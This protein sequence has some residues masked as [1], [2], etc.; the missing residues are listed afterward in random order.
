MLSAPERS[1]AALNFNAIITL[2]QQVG[3]Q[4]LEAMQSLTE[5]HQRLG[6]DLLA[7]LADNQAQWLGSR[8]GA[9]AG[10][11]LIRQF[12]PAQEP[13]RHYQRQLLDLVSMTQ[14]ELLQTVHEHLSAMENHSLQATRAASTANAEVHGTRSALD[15]PSASVHRGSSMHH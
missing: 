7:D 4:L 2:Y 15:A 10:A 12:T 14:S 6:R 3:Q 5:L 13:W 8:D 11:A 1:A 9:S